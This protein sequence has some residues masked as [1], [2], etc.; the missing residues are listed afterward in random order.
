MGLGYRVPCGL[1]ILIRP[2]RL[3]LLRVVSCDFVDVSLSRWSR[4]NHL[5]C[6]CLVTT[7][8]KHK[9]LRPIADRLKALNESVVSFDR[10]LNGNVVGL[11]EA[12]RVGIKQTSKHFSQARIEWRVYR[13]QPHKSLAGLIF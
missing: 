12:R 6:F 2:F 9:P 8:G 11:F 5:Y 3:M 10:G 4:P 7:S 1:E 13:Q